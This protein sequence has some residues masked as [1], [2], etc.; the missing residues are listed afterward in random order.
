MRK[1]PDGR[2]VRI[3]FFLA[4]FASI[5]RS[6]IIYLPDGR[7]QRT[8]LEPAMPHLLFADRTPWD[9]NLSDGL[10]GPRLKH[11]VC[12]CEASFPNRLFRIAE[13]EQVVGQLLDE[14]QDRR[15]DLGMHFIFELL[16]DIGTLLC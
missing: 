8:W 4:I 10:F 15:H 9:L 7:D 11:L 3:D 2:V 5:P 14:F 16:L 6:A 13:F 12:D 1:K